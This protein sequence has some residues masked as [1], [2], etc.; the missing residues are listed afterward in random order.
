[1]QDSALNIIIEIESTLQSIL[2]NDPKR[3]YA[4]NPRR[5]EK[6]KITDTSST[7]S[8][9]TDFYARLASEAQ[10]MA[11]VVGRGLSTQHLL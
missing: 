5:A 11:Q 10:V 6:Y 7:P 2:T 1:M 4:L 9:R 3:A 8:G